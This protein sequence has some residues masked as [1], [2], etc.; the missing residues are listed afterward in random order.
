MS[1]GLRR[2][3]RRASLRI[4]E[5][6]QAGLGA[7]DAAIDHAGTLAQLVGLRLELRRPRFGSV[8]IRFFDFGS[9]ARSI[10]SE[11]FELGIELGADAV[12]FPRSVGPC[13]RVFQGFQAV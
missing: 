1:F 8:E 4:A 6:A 2:G 12:E 10:A 7:S 11:R 5:V 3:V 9:G 13:F